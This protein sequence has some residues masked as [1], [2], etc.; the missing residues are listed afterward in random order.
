VGGEMSLGAAARIKVQDA[1]LRQFR[2]KAL[3]GQKKEKSSEVFGP[4]IDGVSLIL[5]VLH[6]Y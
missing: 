1:L 6:V 2:C 5:Q 4:W 3:G